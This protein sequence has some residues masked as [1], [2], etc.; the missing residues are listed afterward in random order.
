MSESFASASAYWRTEQV[1]THPGSSN[2][3]S[4]NMTLKDDTQVNNEASLADATS[5]VG[6][7]P[8]LVCMLV[9][10]VLSDAGVRAN[11]LESDKELYASPAAVLK[12]RRAQAQPEEVG[13]SIP[14][15]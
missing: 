11:R 14:L 3:L 4:P 5:L 13:K 8:R 2:L 1:D 9:R 7:S 15:D 10:T 6:T 12:T